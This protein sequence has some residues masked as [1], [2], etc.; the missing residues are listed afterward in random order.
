MN[1]RFHWI[2]RFYIT[3]VLNNNKDRIHFSKCDW[4]VCASHLFQ[5]L[6]V[7]KVVTSEVMT[8]ATTRQHRQSEIMTSEIMTS[9][10][11]AR[12]ISACHVF[13]CSIPSTVNSL[14]AKEMAPLRKL[15]VLRRSL[16]HVIQIKSKSAFNWMSCWLMRRPKKR[17]MLLPNRFPHIDTWMLEHYRLHCEIL[18]DVHR[19]A[20]QQ[21]ST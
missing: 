16:V 21:N 4:H 9:V 18:Y 5:F 17:G 3:S 12:F 19:R 20:V 14:Y 7:F 1:V 13:L 8:Y 2:K 15:Q 10:R 6:N 11:A